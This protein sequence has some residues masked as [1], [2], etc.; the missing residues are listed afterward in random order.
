M[1]DDSPPPIT[2]L[3]QRKYPETPMPGRE[4]EE[5]EDEES[6][7]DLPRHEEPEDDQPKSR[8]CENM[9]YF[10]FVT[11]AIAHF[12]TVWTLQADVNILMQYQ[13]E[14]VDQYKHI[15]KLL[16]NM[17]QVKWHMVPAIQ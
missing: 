11:I 1:S 5:D 6:F 16:E 13:K 9:M 12:W 4:S 7:D 17:H 15:A 10:I 3:R 8:L 2:G 14:H